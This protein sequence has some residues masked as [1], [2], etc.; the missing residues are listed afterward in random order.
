MKA[1]IV[2]LLCLLAGVA[3]A[4]P[5]PS[6]GIK[7]VTHDSTLAGA[8]TVAAPLGLGVCVTPGY[9]WV[10]NGSAMTCAAAGGVSDGDKGDIT[11]SGTGSVFTI[12]NS[13]VTLAKMADLATARFIGR[14]TGG[15][16]APEALTG[17]QAT[18]LLDLFSTSGTT[19]G[20]VPGSG[21]ATTSCL[22]GDGTWGSCGTTYSAGSGLQ[23]T[24][25]TFSANL[26]GASCSAGSFVSALSSTGTGTCTA[27][28]GD[29]TDV[30]AGTNMTGGGST[31]SVTVNL[32]S[33]LSGLTS[34]STASLSNSGPLFDTGAIT[35][36]ALAGTTQNNYAPTGLSTARYIL[37]DASAATTITGL[38]AGSDGQV[39]TLVNIG[40]TQANTLTITNE[41]SNSTAANRFTLIRALPWTLSTGSTITFRYSTSSA[42]WRMVGY[43]GNVF[44]LSGSASNPSIV[45]GG[46]TR[47]IADDG[48]ANGLL[49]A[50]GSNILG[51]GTGGVSIANG[52]TLSSGNLTT[53]ATS[54]ASLGGNLRL[55][56]SISPASISG[57]QNDY[58]PTGLTSTVTVRIAATADVTMTGMLN[59]TGFTGRI[60][61]LCNISSFTIAITNEDAGSVAANRFSLPNSASVILAANECALV[62]YD[63]TSSRWRIWSALGR[64]GVT[65]SPGTPTANHGTLG[66]G[67][68]D[69]WG[70]VA[71]VGAFTSVVLTYSRAYTNRSWCTAT[72]ESANQFIRVTR[73]ASAPT[74]SCFDTTGAAANCGDFTY[75][76]AGQ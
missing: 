16:G 25:S 5:V 28:T 24:G 10:S 9:A 26:A 4:Q 76:C 58:N 40:T 11:I 68:T 69:S 27:E 23:L 30:V 21:G 67:S 63:S 19:K 48:T 43:A 65:L 18:S 60:L 32:A 66:T 31:G 47:G 70:N 20:L 39:V 51:W 45:V 41:D 38:T 22:K 71:S 33:S 2:L 55:L 17:T 1:R 37:Q 72:P 36:T 15:T 74:F 14:I 52:L 46:T 7:T 6:G 61:N 64:G 3:H 44:S 53:P 8:G 50:G 35:P 62:Y 73:S 56:T 49:V 12:D 13:V 54:T 29:I 42:R 59:T 34:V 57:A 75:S